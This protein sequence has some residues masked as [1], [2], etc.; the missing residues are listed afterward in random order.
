V[1]RPR[2]R[3]ILDLLAH[4]HTPR[5]LVPLFPLPTMFSPQSACPHHGEIRRGSWF[6][7]MICHR[8]GMDHH[9]AL[10]IVTAEMPEP[11]RRRYIPPAPPGRKETRREKRARMFGN[12]SQ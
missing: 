11:E 5:F 10:Q 9:P 1:R 4:L 2:P 12:R 7:C 3:G 6:C 8:S